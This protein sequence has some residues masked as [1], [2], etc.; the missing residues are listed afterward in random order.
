MVLALCLAA[1]AV[2][3]CGDDDGGIDDTGSAPDEVL[4]T[5]KRPALPSGWRRVVNARAGYSFGLP[6]GWKVTGRPGSNQ[7]RAFDGALAGSV[8]ADRSDQG[9]TVRPAVYSRQ[10]ARS[11]QGFRDL[12]IRAPRAVIDVRYPTAS[13][14]ATGTLRSNRLHQEIVVFALKPKG[15]ATYSLVLFRAATVPAARYAPLLEAMVRSFRV[16]EREL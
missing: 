15:G 6:P 7:I 14:T 12:R 3:G 2:A 13:V 8:T 5:D 4:R 9:L 11:L 16:Q 1:G 10:T